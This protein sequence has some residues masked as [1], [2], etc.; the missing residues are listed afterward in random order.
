[1]SEHNVSWSGRPVLDNDALAFRHIKKEWLDQERNLFCSKWFDYRYLHF[2]EATELYAEDYVR[3]YREVYADHM[4]S[5]SSSH[6][7]PIKEPLFCLPKPK[8][9]GLWRG[10][11]VA[12]AIGMPYGLFISRA[13]RQTLRYWR[14]RYMPQPQQLYAA[15]VVEAVIDDWTERQNAVFLYSERPEYRNAAYVG[16]PPQNDHHEWLFAQAMKRGNPAAAFA[17]LLKAELLPEAKL[18][19]RVDA[20]LLER[21]RAYR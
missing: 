16:S 17:D 13:M 18:A 2:V 4:D 20:D 21:I 3:V 7:S 14:N 1:M 8:L 11:Q 9:S 15:R 12:D 6:V 5:R 19:A 10:R